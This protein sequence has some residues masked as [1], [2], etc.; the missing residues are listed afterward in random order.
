[1][2]DQNFPGTGD[3]GVDLLEAI[4]RAAGQV[5][6][7]G[8]NADTLV[9]SPSD[10]LDLALAKQPFGAMLHEVARSEST[11]PLYYGLL[12]VWVRLLGTSADAL[13]S[14]SACFGV[15]TVVVVYLAAR[16]RFSLQLAQDFP[17][18]GSLA[19]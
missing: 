10:L 19:A 17:R 15:L 2:I 8:Y 9:M 11:P 7:N 18:T 6:D 16:L 13:R 5:A 4:A 1:M 14:L 12:W 3:P